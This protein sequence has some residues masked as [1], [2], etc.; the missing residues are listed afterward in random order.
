MPATKKAA[1]V[2]AKWGGSSPTL[3]VV[4]GEETAAAKSFRNIPAVVVASAEGVG[5]A[6]I[7]G[8]RS[9]VI[10]EASLEVLERRSLAVSRGAG[11]SD[12]GE[13]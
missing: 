5:V 2:L 7:V 6:E 3:I 4:T 9:L 11:G 13:G 8:A 12:G 1:E 10:S